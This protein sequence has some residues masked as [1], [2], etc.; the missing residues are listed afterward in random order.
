LL[1]VGGGSAA[2]ATTV[3]QAYAHLR[4]ITFDLPAVASLARERVVSAGLAGRLDVVSG[5]M[6]RDPLPSRADVI[7]LSWILHDWDDSK[8]LT[9]LRRCYAALERGGAIIVLEALLDED[10]TGPAAA[11]GLSLTMLVAT[12]G[13]RERS[14]SEYIALLREAGF[15]RHEVRYLHNLQG[16]HCIVGWR[17]QNGATG[18]DGERR[19]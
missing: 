13:G 7:T 10:G 17:D 16:R 11:A 3:L 18:D 2:L 1:D 12:Q 9:L 6:F 14:A 15:V 19:W 5:D 8:A 4:G